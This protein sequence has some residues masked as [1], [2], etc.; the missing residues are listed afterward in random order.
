MTIVGTTVL[1]DD[2]EVAARFLHSLDPDARAFTFQLLSDNKQHAY[3]EV[4]HGSLD[5]LWDR[6]N[7]LKTTHQIGVFVAVNE[8]DGKGRKAENI[9]R[10]RAVFIDADSAEQV[11]RCETTF[12]AVGATPSVVV[13]SS[14]GKAHYYFFVENLPRNEFTPLQKA[15]SKKLGTDASVT[16]LPRIMR[17]PGTAHLKNAANPHLVTAEYPDQNMR[18][19]NAQDLIGLLSLDLQP[20]SQVEPVGVDNLAPPF[21]RAKRPIISHV[22]PRIFERAR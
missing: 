8:T 3:S 17:L 14:P 21:A 2:K 16:D 18:R 1:P 9:T 5:Q 7:Q 19:W 20:E 15:L 6:V 4:I 10:V 22:R 11:A 13:R 12:A